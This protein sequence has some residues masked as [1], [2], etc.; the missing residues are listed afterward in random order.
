MLYTFCSH[1]GCS[2]GI[3]PSRLIQDTNGNFY[4]ATQGGGGQTCGCGTVYSLSTGLE[5]FVEA[6]PAF[7]SVGKR[8]AILGNGLSGTT[9]VTF[10]GT[11]ATFKVGSGTYILVSIPPGATTGPIE[12]TT[13]SGTLSSNVAFQIVP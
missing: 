9:S 5:P 6:V 10:N 12:V 1:G 13:P 7:G 3:G 4:G 8:V 2:D 11:P